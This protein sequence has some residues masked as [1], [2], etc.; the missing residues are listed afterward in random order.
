MTP[1][2]DFAGHLAYIAL[3]VGL[4]LLGREDRRGFPLR[5]AGELTWVVLGW[6][7][8]ASSIVTWGLVF[9]VVEAY[10]WRRWGHP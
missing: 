1:V 6:Q 9:V 2:Q 10:G 5:A 3:C 8:G 4:I 7:I